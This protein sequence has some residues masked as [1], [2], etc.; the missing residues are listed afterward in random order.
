[1]PAAE[2][3]LGTGRAMEPALNPR[4]LVQLVAD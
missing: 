1:M 3:V 4:V 2:Q